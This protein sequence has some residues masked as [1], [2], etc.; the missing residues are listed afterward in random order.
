M[1]HFGHWVRQSLSLPILVSKLSGEWWSLPYKWYVCLAVTTI[2]VTLVNY[3]NCPIS[4]TWR[5]D[6]HLISEMMYIFFTLLEGRSC[7]H[8]YSLIACMIDALINGML[9]MKI[10]FWWTSRTGCKV[11]WLKLILTTINLCF[12]C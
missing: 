9:L 3:D 5:S 11:I 1:G 2:L 4:E 12:E 8:L 10:N 6:H 7:D